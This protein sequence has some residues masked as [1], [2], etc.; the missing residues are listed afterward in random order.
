MKI[1]FVSSKDSDEICNMSTKC[2]N[3]EITM[4]S[5]TDY[6][7]EELFESLLEKYQEGLE[8]SMRGSEFIIDSV[9]LFYYHLQKQV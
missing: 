8:K 7:M 2:D 5:E 3:I 1:I 9:D 6:I 4:V